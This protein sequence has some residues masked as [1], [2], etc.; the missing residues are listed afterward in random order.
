MQGNERRGDRWKVHG[1]RCGNAS[2]R[3][4]RGWREQRRMKERCQP[5]VAFSVGQ[6]HKC[7]MLPTSIPSQPFLLLIPLTSLST[8]P[9][10]FHSTSCCPSQSAHLSL[11]SLRLPRVVPVVIFAFRDEGR[12]ME[13]MEMQAAQLPWYRRPTGM[14][15]RPGRMCAFVCARVCAG[16]GVSAHS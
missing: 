4:G 8:S 13:H 15:P 9:C 10:S 6:Q 3:S 12:S 14:A 7:Q 5:E 1:S 11:A 2:H 16:V